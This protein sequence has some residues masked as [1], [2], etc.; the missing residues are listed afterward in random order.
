MDG[1]IEGF[2]SGET[3]VLDICID[4]SV[5]TLERRELHKDVE[6]LGSINIAVG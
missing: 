3:V 2:E 5:S 4:P 1:A 6:I